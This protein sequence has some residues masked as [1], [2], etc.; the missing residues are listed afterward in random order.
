M[1]TTWPG[2]PQTWWDDVADVPSDRWVPGPEDLPTCRTPEA[3]GR[4][5]AV[6]APRLSRAAMPNLSAFVLGA[7]VPGALTSRI[8][9][10]WA[11]VGP[12]RPTAGRPLGGLPPAAT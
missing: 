6:V 2:S 3:V 12:A 8:R 10:G 9:F 4:S 1:T 7:A 5:Y 11:A